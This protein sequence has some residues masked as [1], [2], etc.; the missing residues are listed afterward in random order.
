[1]NKKVTINDVAKLANVSKSTVSKYLNSIP[2]VSEITAKKIEESINILDYH[3]S[4]VARG[5]VSKSINLIVLVISNIE[6]L[7]NFLLVKTIEN[8]AKK[9]GYDIV[10]MTTNDDEAI[11]RNLTEILTVRYKHVDGIILANIRKNGAD[12]R[13]LKQTFKNVVLVHR[14][15]PNSIVDYVSIN[16]Y[17]GGQIVAKYLKN[18]G[19]E[20]VA[21]ISGPKEILPYSERVKGFTDTL[22][23]FGFKKDNL[24]FTEENQTLAAAYEAAEKIMSIPNPPTSIF[25]TSDLLAFG[26][27]DAAKAHGWEIP[28]DFSLIGFDNIFF[29]RLARVPLTTI[30]GQFDILGK[31]AVSFLIDRLNNNEKKVQQTFLEP[32]LIIRES[33]ALPQQ[34]NK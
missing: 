21:V 9:Y 11:E 15:I 13:R 25:A 26:V 6:L 2:Y 14:Y 4:S 7:N 28:R 17:K 12:V 29:S 32:S 24:L 8:E 33:S 30:D 23:D 31:K 3:P 10:L 34:M 22:K 27:L 18:L 20:K 1:M 19:H 16:N 5:L